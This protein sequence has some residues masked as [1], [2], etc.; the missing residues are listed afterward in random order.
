MIND[1]S[2]LV[3]HDMLGHRLSVVL[4]GDTCDTTSN[5][6][7]RSKYNHGSLEMELAAV[8]KTAS[9]WNIVMAKICRHHGALWSEPLFV[10]LCFGIVI[11][12][13]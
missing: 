5:L 4:P 8:A 7:S 13:P 3:V 11:H 10:Q 9:A 12:T 1:M 6:A 2:L